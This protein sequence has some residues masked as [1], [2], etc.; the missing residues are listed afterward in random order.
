[1]N[2][3]PISNACH[4]FMSMTLATNVCYANNAGNE[5]KPF[6]NINKSNSQYMS[7]RHINNSSDQCML[8]AHS[9]E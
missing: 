5:G 9:N 8:I 4:L 1:M 2:V 7:I 6:S 3:I